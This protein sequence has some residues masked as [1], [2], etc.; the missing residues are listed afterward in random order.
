[1]G[2]HPASVAG[3]D[4]SVSHVLAALAVL[5]LSVG[6]LAAGYPKPA[7]VP[8][9]WELTFEP[10]DLRLYRDPDTSRYFWWFTYSVTNRTNG[11]QLWAP[12]M[13]LFTD[14]GE[15]IPAGKEV[16]SHVTEALLGMMNNQFLEDQNEIIGDILQGKEH[17]KEGLVVWRANSL[18]VNELSLF[19]SGTSGETARVRNPISGSEVILR[20]TLQRDY[21][22]P[23]DATARGSEPAQLMNQEWVMR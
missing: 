11:V 8:Y 2:R 18:A 9:R 21:L 22:I 12:S 4:R 17:M 23:G 10:G 13:V 14:T 16:P 6:A 3:Q 1:M 19:I 15:I 7:A 5:V 20:K